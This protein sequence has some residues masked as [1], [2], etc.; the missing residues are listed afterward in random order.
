MFS[1]QRRFMEPVRVQLLPEFTGVGRRAVRLGWDLS[2]VPSLKESQQAIW[3]RAVGALK[4]GGITINDFR[5]LVSLPNIGEAGDVFLTPAGVV[6]QPIGASRE[7][8]PA[9][10]V[11]ASYGLLAA[12]FGIELSDAE[13]M[14]LPS[15]EEFHNGR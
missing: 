4:A 8:S 12:E 10:S 15:G 3:D 6:S 14:A 13:L 5:R 1:E 11:S 7:L 2:G 9:E